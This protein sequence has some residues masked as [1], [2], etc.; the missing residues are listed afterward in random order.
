MTFVKSLNGHSGCTVELL[1]D[2]RGELLVR[3]ISGS[4]DYDERLCKQW[5]K[6][7]NSRQQVL[8]P[9]V[10]GSGRTPNGRFY[11]DMEY[12]EGE[13]LAKYINQIS[14]YETS[15]IAQSLMESLTGRRKDSLP[16][17]TSLFKEK[18]ESLESKL[19]FNE[20][21]QESLVIL[22]DYNWSEVK[23]S[24]CHGDMTL[25]NIIVKDGDLYFVD[26]LDSFY[27]SWL[28]DVSTLLQDT[29]IDW[30]YRTTPESER[31]SNKKIF[32]SVVLN[33][34]SSQEIE[35]VMHCLLLKLLRIIPYTHDEETL[36]FLNRGIEKVLHI[37]KT[38][39]IEE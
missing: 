15:L 26:F 31:P 2:D 10:L 35:D 9:I 1:K 36:A 22:K 12:I 11:F 3:K 23:R 25:E 39:S 32:T 8:A 34:L 19:L 29:L 20:S 7:E 5:L 38:R 17:K 13:T 37:I 16:A 4:A 30:A 6:Q 18:I 14:A 21:I 28:L 24:W 33:N 27:E